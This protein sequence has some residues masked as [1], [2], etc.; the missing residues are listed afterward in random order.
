MRTLRTSP[1]ES[2]WCR[3]LVFRVRP[4]M[5]LMMV[6]IAAAVV[7]DKQ[8]EAIYCCCYCSSFLSC[9]CWRSLAV[10][11]AGSNCFWDSSWS[12]RESEP[13]R[14]LGCGLL[15]AMSWRAFERLRS[16][17][18]RIR[19]LKKRLFKCNKLVRNFKT[20]KILTLIKDMDSNHH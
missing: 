12:P 1:D 14:T 3:W 11:V 16:I 7:P 18:E 6:M 5:I 13:R 8:Q 17:A 4:T 2:I 20:V 9:C 19:P 10:G 15:D